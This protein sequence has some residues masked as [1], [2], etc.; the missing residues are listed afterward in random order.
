MAM[1]DWIAKLDDFL[2]LSDRDLP[3]LAGSVSH[4]CGARQGGIRIR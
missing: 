3:T 4:E 2:R 1:R